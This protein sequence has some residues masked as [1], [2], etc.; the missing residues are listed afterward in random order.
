MRRVEVAMG[1][2]VTHAGDVDPWDRW[3]GVKE[4]RADSLDGF[5]DLDQPEPDGIEHQAIIERPSLPVG[6][7]C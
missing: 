2:L 1:E 6:K 3:L 4:F 7:D 5:A